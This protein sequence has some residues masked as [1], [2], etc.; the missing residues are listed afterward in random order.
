MMR[1]CLFFTNVLVRSAVRYPTVKLA[2]KTN[3]SARNF[4][5]TSRYKLHILQGLRLGV[6]APMTRANSATAGRSADSEDSIVT[7]HPCKSGKH[8]SNRH[9]QRTRKSTVSISPVPHTLFRGGHCFDRRKLW[10][11]PYDI[12]PGEFCFRFEETTGLW[13]RSRDQ[14][15]SST[16]QRVSAVSSAQLRPRCHQQRSAIPSQ[17]PRVAH[18]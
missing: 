13:R 2:Q 1:P 6:S 8:W 14:K 16:R 17:R 3:C 12:A 15:C 4:N 11:N 7:R 9:K 18:L 10:I 5:N